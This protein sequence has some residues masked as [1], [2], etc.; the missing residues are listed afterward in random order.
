MRHGGNHLKASPIRIFVVD[1]E[2][3]RT[4]RESVLTH[5]NE[6]N[7][8]RGMTSWVDGTFNTFA[9][10]ALKC[11]REHHRPAEGCIDYWR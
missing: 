2:Q 1:D 4:R 10:D 8:K 9:D 7:K 11:F 6:M 5:I 3:W